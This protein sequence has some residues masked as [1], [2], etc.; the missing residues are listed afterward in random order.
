M[1]RRIHLAVLALVLSLGST[2]THAQ[3]PSAAPTSTAALREIR[4]E[5]LKSLTQP[6]A[7]T[8]SGLQIGAQ[9]GRD[10]LQAGAD[11]LVQTGLFAHVTYKFQ[12]RADGLVVTFQLE[13]AHPIPA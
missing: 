7:A 6:Q 13:E 2:P 10:D 3:T 12:S 11:K 5:G 8:I 1:P 4:A 9:V